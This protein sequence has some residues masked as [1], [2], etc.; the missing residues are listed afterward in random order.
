MRHERKEEKIVAVTSAAM[1]ER[2]RDSVKRLGMDEFLV[3]V[4]AYKK[5]PNGF[6]AT[7]FRLDDLKDY[8]DKFV[9]PY[10][11]TLNDEFVFSQY[12]KTKRN[13]QNE[14]QVD[15]GYFIPAMFWDTVY[16][17]AKTL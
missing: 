14:K 6:T 16:K 3:S 9:A 1:I 12:A 2:V 11:S 4:K 17:M 15:D 5:T 8:E 10:K 13:D 7:K